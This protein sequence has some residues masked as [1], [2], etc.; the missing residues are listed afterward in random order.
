MKILRWFYF[1]LELFLSYLVRRNYRARAGLLP[2]ELLELYRQEIKRLH[3]N[4]K[5]ERLA[6]GRGVS[7]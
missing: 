5:A 4:N 1:P 7:K 6:W 3:E 2:D